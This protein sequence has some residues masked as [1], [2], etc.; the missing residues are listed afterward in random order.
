[1][2][3]RRLR[4]PDDVA[5]FIRGLHPGLKAK[6]RAGLDA[7]LADSGA[8]KPLKEE[9]AGYR[10]LRVGKFRIV[11]RPHK[12]VVEIVAVGP[13]RVIYAETW[14]RIRPR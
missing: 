1:M 12:T 13:R 11:C 14:R 6:V 5:D 4:V 2:A 8:G 9:L 10:S 7:I 3:V